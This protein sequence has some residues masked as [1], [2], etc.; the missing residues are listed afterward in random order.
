MCAGAAPAMGPVE[1]G[2]IPRAHHASHWDATRGGRPLYAL[3][4]ALHQASIIRMESAPG[5]LDTGRSGLR[6]EWY[7]T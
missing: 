6:R 7:R 5:A 1:G 4:S 3:D 2:A